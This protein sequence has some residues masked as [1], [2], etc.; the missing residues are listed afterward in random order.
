MKVTFLWRYAPLVALILALAALFWQQARALELFARYDWLAITFPYPLDYGEGPI[1]DQTLRLAR[2]QNIYRAD[3]S[4]PPFTIS[5]YPPLFLL[6]QAPF[7]A[8][9]GPALWYGRALSTI[10]ILL[11]AVC[12]GLTLWTL[13][14]DWIAATVGGLMLPT[15][16]FILHWSAFNRVDA[17]ALGLSWAGL[18]V[19]ARWPERRAGLLASGLLL[20]AAIYTRQSYALAAPLAAFVWLVW[21]PPRRRAFE[22]AALVG[23]LSLG[24]FVIFNLLTGGGFFF[25]IVT[26]NVNSFHWV[27]VRDRVDEMKRPMPYLAAMS[28]VFLLAGAGRLRAWRMVGPYLVGAALSAL[29]IGKAGSNVNYLFELSAGLSLAAG[30]L[31]ALTR[32]W[33]WVRIALVALLAWQVAGLQEWSHERYVQGVFDRVAARATL[34]RIDAL[35]RE[36]DG[37]VLADEYMAFVPLNGRPLYFQPFEFKQLAEAGLWDQSRF[38]E[39]IRQQE[40]AVILLYET[41]SW[42]SR[43]ERWTE[44]QN[45]FITMRYQRT[46]TIMETGVYRPGPGVSNV[47]RRV[48]DRADGNHTKPAAE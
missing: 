36:T 14:R 16:P 37:I 23:G 25:N 1:L 6:A 48:P 32:S 24:L 2:F 29:T 21:E 34:E 9:F 13:T 39:A 12:I 30:A 40:F 8:A 46:E 4:Q 18:F 5:N 27:Q 26:A 22:L 33:P 47:T 15:I 11:A 20:T 31:L 7:A 41:A 44:E 28:G 17:L 19:I 35:V 43:G 3:L 45:F 38:V 42:D 10:S